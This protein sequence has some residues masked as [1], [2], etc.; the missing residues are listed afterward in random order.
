MAEQDFL[1]LIEKYLAGEATPAEEQLLLGFFESFQSES[2]W[3]ETTLG[4]KQELEDKMLNRLQLAVKKSAQSEKSKTISLFNLRNIAA[5]AIVLAF[6]AAGYYYFI[7]KTPNK[8]VLAQ[9]TVKS[10]NDID[11]GTNKAILTLANG[12]KLILNNAKVGAVIKQNNISIKKTADGQLVYE[13]AEAANTKDKPVEYNTISTPRGGQYQVILPD[14]SKVWLNA[15]SSLT[16]PTAFN[17]NERKVTL[18]GEA[19]FEV[20]KNAA[21][22]F[23]VNAGSLDVKVLGTHFN[24]MAYNDEDE[25]KT[26]LLEGSVQLTAANTS[27]ILKPGQQGS[28]SK[29]GRIAVTEANTEEAVAWKNGYFEFD[30]ANIQTIMKQVSRWYDADI[31]Y[32]G[33]LT[34]DEFVGK[35]DR[36]VK[37]SQLL[38][39]LEVSKVHYHIEG[40]KIIVKP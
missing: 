28:L 5:A 19:Y 30:R 14:G 9:Q 13:V 4:I 2:D 33:A 31:T 27:G 20:A 8:L 23:K 15:A 39:I 40:K 10:Q 35:I 16:Y 32:E 34:D 24:V 36:S 12:S 22:P 38:H 29:N 1:K 26:T 17:G 25:I 3:D 7:A 11:P 6:S 37:L 18:T 21:K